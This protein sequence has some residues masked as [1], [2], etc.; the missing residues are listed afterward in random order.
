MAINDSRPISWDLAD[1]S[2]LARSTN[3]FASGD[4]LIG[5]IAG[6]IAYSIALRHQVKL[7]ITDG[8][9]L[10][11]EEQMRR[12]LETAVTL[13]DFNETSSVIV[14][15]LRDTLREQLRAKYDVRILAP[16]ELSDSEPC[17]GQTLTPS[18]ER[19]RSE[20]SEPSPDAPRSDS[21][22]KS[23]N[24]GFEPWSVPLPTEIP[25]RPSQEPAT[26][27]A[28]SAPSP[29]NHL[30]IEVVI[31]SGETTPVSSEEVVRIV[32]HDIATNGTIR[33]VMKG[34]V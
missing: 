11:D 31:R 29:S 5:A 21:P 7:P 19:P 2:R 26:P 17:G 30:L 34:S 25:F 8:V 13:V 6:R 20:P 14:E 3:P 4:V 1:L 18:A 22:E 15:A 28:E 9:L 33:R 32:A 10:F 27:T 16:S 24:A 23:E 12:D